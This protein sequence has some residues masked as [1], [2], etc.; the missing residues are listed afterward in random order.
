MRIP[1]RVNF[2]RHKTLA[3]G[4]TGVD[5]AGQPIPRAMTKLQFGNIE[6]IGNSDSNFDC[7]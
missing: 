7:G 1:S 5:P 6:D 4:A 2:L 3:L